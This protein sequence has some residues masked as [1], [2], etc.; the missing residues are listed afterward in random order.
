MLLLAPLF[1]WDEVSTRL[2]DES[3]VLIV[4]ACRA[5]VQT[6]NSALFARVVLC[7]VVCG[8]TD[9]TGVEASTIHH[10]AL[11]NSLE[12]TR[13]AQ[14]ATVTQLFAVAAWMIDCVVVP[15]WLLA[16]SEGAVEDWEWR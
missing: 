11:N 8:T 2:M 5:I 15:L 4:A 10:E 3:S 7:N 1:S 13:T 9:A 6:M 12:I 14:F 16:T